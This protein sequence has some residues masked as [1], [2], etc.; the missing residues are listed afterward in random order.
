MIDLSVIIVN[1]NS[2][3]FLRECLRS[4]IASQC[5]Y[6][7]QVFVVDNGSTDGS[8]EMV[9]KFFPMV[10]IEE[11]ASNV[12]F[13]KANNQIMKRVD[14]SYFLLLN[15][16]TIVHPNAFDTMVAFLNNSPDAGAV[17]PAILN[18]D[19]TPQRTGTKFPNNWNLFVEALLLDRLFPKTRLFGSHKELYIDFNV[20]REVDYV[21]GSCV[22][23]RSSLLQSIGYLDERFFM[24]FEETDLCFRIKR[25][26][27]KIWFLPKASI[28]HFGGDATA[29]YDER[30]LIHYHNSLVQFYSKHYVRSAR[31]VLRGILF[32]RSSIRIVVWWMVY[33]FR[34]S[35]RKAAFSTIKGYVKTL[36]LVYKERIH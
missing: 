18:A 19:S 20:L 1:W 30:R 16:D 32:M 27:W 10:M 7:Y 28:I 24:Y 11:N 34:P 15:P 29:H 35:L 25:A 2:K 23:L 9:K 6:S 26:G 36:Q 3:D 4:I 12:G 21:Q 31:Y 5:R 22:M 8:V 14:S 17:G 33:L 13:V